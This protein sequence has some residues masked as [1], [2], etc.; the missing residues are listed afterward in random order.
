MTKTSVTTLDKIK[1]RAYWTVEF[2][3]AEFI[4]NALEFREIPQIL[5]RASVKYRGWDYPHITR[6][7]IED[8]QEC[9]PMENTYYE[10]WIDWSLFKE[11]WRVYKSGKF[12]HLFGVTEQWWDEYEAVFA[13][14]PYPDL[15]PKYIDVPN[16]VYKVTEMVEFIHNFANA[17]EGVDNF[18]FRVK[19]HGVANNELKTF[20]RSRIPLSMSYK[21]RSEVIVGYDSQ[22]SKQ[23]LSSKD[24]RYDLEKDIIQNI[25]NHFDGWQW[26]DDIIAAER[27]KLVER[28]L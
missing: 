26:T 18:I 19:L 15:E 7:N 8:R 24:E 22:V 28:R 14:N 23:L 21:N 25:F 10:G 2:F 1:Q 16:V 13:E 27:E 11:R 17:I 6:E 4:G 20:D 12:V 5:D 9:Y 3:P